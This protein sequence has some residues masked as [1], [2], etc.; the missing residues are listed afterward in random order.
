[1]FVAYWLFWLLFGWG[2]VWVARGFGLSWGD[3][4]APAFLIVVF[5]MGSAAY[6]AKRRRLLAEG[7]PPPPYLA[8]VFPVDPKKNIAFPRP[9]RMLVGIVFLPLGL[10]LLIAMVA[11]LAEAVQRMSLLA[12][13]AIAFFG[14]ISLGI[15]YVGWRLLVMRDGERLIRPIKG[16]HQ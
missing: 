9:V 6:L 12:L 15:V 16:V 2:I 7:K 5:G 1:M 11:G 14:P 13:V 4:I 10:L 3:S 8:T